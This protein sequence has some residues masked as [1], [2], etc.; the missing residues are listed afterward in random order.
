M[1]PKHHFLL[2]LVFVIVLVL[3]FD[4]TYFQAFIILASSILIDADH[5]LFYI[6]K[7][8]DYSLIKAYY[9]FKNLPKDHKPILQLF[10]TIEFM[11]FLAVLSYSSYYALLVLL[12]VLFHSLIDICY[13]IAK[14][15]FNTREFSII[16][17]L[18]SDKRQYF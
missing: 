17:Y 7:K 9:W 15:R 10:H 11:I 12:G 14:K 16:K 1:L 4:I 8:K 6:N 3:F 18:I 2:G 13:M 5:Y